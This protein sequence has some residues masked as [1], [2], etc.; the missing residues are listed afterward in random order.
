MVVV[1]HALDRID[2]PDLWFPPLA[3]HS[4]E[5]L[6]VD[7]SERRFTYGQHEAAERHDDVAKLA[8]ERATPG[9]LHA[10]G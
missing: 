10:S 4:P 3:K 8:L 5:A 9:E 1:D 2:H 7:A 6:A